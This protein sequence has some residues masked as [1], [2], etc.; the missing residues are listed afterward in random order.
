M[1]AHGTVLYGDVGTGELRHG[2]I[3]GSSTN[4][5]YLT[6]GKQGQMIFGERRLPIAFQ[7]DR[8]L[9]VTDSKTSAPTSLEIFPACRRW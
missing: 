7:S 5:R 2:P 1:D 9:V 6:D 8:S 3:D 4:V